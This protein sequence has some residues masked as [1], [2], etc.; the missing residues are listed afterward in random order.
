M[1]F[2]HWFTKKFSVDV[3]AE[4][5][6]YLA[7]HP[8]GVENGYGPKLWSAETIQGRANTLIG[9]TVGRAYVGLAS[10]RFNRQQRKRNAAGV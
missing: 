9:Q 1:N 6:A 7:E 3:P 2:A 10:A 4:F 5:E 8:P